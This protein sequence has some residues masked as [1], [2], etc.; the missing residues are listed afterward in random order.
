MDMPAGA[1]GQPAEAGALQQELQQ[2]YQQGEGVQ[3]QAAHPG[4][5]G[6][7]VAPTG[8]GGGADGPPAGAG[9]ASGGGGGRRPEDP[10]NYPAFMPGDAEL[11]TMMRNASIG[12]FTAYNGVSVDQFNAIFMDVGITAGDYYQTAAMVA[13]GELDEILTSAKLNDRPIPWG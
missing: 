12:V 10:Y 2:Q 7:P 13:P 9:P 6:A 4:T 11:A 5:A 3:Q 8:G 1:V